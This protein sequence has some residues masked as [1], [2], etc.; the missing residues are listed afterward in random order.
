MKSLQAMVRTVNERFNYMPRWLNS[1][2]FSMGALFI[3]VIWLCF[4]FYSVSTKAQEEKST[5]TLMEDSITKLEQCFIAKP[6]QIICMHELSVLSRLI[7]LFEGK[8]YLE[9][10]IWGA[11]HAYLAS[12]FIDT[13][14]NLP[15]NSALS[16]QNRLVARS[17]AENEI[18][19]V[20]RFKMITINADSNPSNTQDKYKNLV[21]VY[22]SSLKTAYSLKIKRLK[23]EYRFK[24]NT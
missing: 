17:L 23:T 24:F 1:K 19:D 4:A 18:L 22:R 7:D 10:Q 6:N 3:L 2:V 9:A 16:L 5:R 13:L 12:E 14:E 15:I 20:D 11:A 21:T 8:T